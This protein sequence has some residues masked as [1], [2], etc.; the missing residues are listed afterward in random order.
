MSEQTVVQVDSYWYSQL[1]SMLKG[2][3]KSLL[4]KIMVEEA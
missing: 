1:V 2:K 4:M 3:K